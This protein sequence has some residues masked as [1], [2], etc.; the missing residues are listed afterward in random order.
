MLS[1]FLIFAILLTISNQNVKTAEAP[2]EFTEPSPLPFRGAV[3]NVSIVLGIC[4]LLLVIRA[5]N[6]Q[7][8]HDE[9]LMIQ[10]ARVITQDGV[11]RPQRNPRLNLLA[12]SI[13]RGN[14]YDRNG[15]LLATNSW[16]DLEKRRA[17]FQRLGIS[18][19]QACSRL[20]ARHYP[21]GPVTAHLLGDVRTQDNFHATNTSFVERDSAKRLQGY[22]D[23]RELGSVVRYRH[24]RGNPSSLR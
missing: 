14:I 9:E 20:E 17:D 11:K 1:N 21:F 2:A 16:Q 22:A 3:R 7:V 24:Q 12:A 10:E 8:F 4:A 13:P 23:Y 19:D 6:I 15:M 18:I 5:A